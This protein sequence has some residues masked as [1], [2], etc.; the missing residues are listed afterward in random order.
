[1]K[2]PPVILAGSDREA[3]GVHIMSRTISKGIIVGMFSKSKISAYVSRYSKVDHTLSIP[4][5]NLLL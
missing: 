1:M 2:S 4:N 3:W 5:L